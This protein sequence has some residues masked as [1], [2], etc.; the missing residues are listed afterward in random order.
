MEL[1]ADF[2]TPVDATSIPTGEIRAVSG[3]MDLRQRGKVGRAINQA[4]NGMG[5]D[6][7]YVLRAPNGEDG[8]R[9]VARVWEP[10]R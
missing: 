2:Y 6:H 1:A 8:L 7:N 10:N 5:Y 4:D 9:S 3:A